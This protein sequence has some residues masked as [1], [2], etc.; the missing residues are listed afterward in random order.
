MSIPQSNRP[1]F[2][3]IGKKYAKSFVSLYHEFSVLK[4]NR[5]DKTI[6]ENK[7]KKHLLNLLFY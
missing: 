4:I 7:L 1:Y 5:D 6:F 2:R 3:I